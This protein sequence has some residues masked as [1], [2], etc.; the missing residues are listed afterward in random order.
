MRKWKIYFPL[1]SFWG[2][3]LVI[4]ILWGILR[5]SVWNG[6]M[7]LRHLE[8]DEGAL[9]D[10]TIKGKIADS[11]NTWDFSIEDGKLEK[12]S[13]RMG[14]EM[15]YPREQTGGTWK[16]GELEVWSSSG[17][18]V[19]VADS[20]AETK[21]TVDLTVLKGNTYF[22]NLAYQPDGTLQGTTTVFDK[23]QAVFQLEMEARADGGAKYR[24]WNYE[25]PTNLVYTPDKPL[26]EVCVENGEEYRETKSS[27]LWIREAPLLVWSKERQ[28]LYG[29]MATNKYC[30]GSI[31]LYC[32]GPDPA[33]DYT[34][35]SGK[36]GQKMTEPFATMAE[37]PVSENRLVLGLEDVKEGLL[38]FIGE[39]DG[40]TV[41]YYS[42]DG[43]LLSSLKQQ[44]EMP[45]DGLQIQQTDWEGGRGIYVIGT[46]EID[47]NAH[48][49][50]LFA[51][52][53]VE[54]GKLKAVYLPESSQG[55]V[56]H[57]VVGKDRVL[58]VRYLQE[59]WDGK[60]K[61]PEIYTSNVL[62]L[63]VYDVS[64]DPAGRMI[65]R[66]KL[67]TDIDEDTLEVLM[68]CETAKG[69]KSIQEQNTRGATGWKRYLM[70]EDIL[71]KG[72]ETI[73]EEGSWYHY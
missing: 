8:G 69:R 62:E 45:V 27:E 10:F 9:A 22:P 37:I 7:E 5:G 31:G 71:G 21:D 13:F 47:D 11:Q 1:V 23:G 36:D 70:V 54:D 12:M 49:V 29:T 67:E 35:A 19:P 44:T 34:S 68:S 50:H 33:E 40:L 3:L 2:S 65:Y 14:V 20:Q 24:Q 28:M 15:A 18:F 30:S 42:Y 53:W 58:T 46:S 41:E 25:I 51:G 61:V 72:G 4:C 55:D 43:V 63:C 6:Q 64:E 57:G 16:E 26:A 59:L 73:W 66:G 56:T 17:T 32:F 38:L 48:Y 39:A 60:A 52:Y